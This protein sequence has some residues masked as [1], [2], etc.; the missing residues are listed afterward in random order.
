MGRGARVGRVGLIA[1][2]ARE[3]RG[4]RM[5]Q[6]DVGMF[7]RAEGGGRMAQPVLEDSGGR[8][9]AVE[10][11]GQRLIEDEVWDGLGLGGIEGRGLVEE[12]ISLGRAARGRDG[13]RCVWELQV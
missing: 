5:T 8:P 4:A 3:V 2:A 7:K 9:S 10:L 13:R 6:W 11:V 12:E 1:V